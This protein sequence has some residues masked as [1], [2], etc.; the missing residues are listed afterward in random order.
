MVFI[1]P[2]FNNRENRCYTFN[3]NGVEKE[4]WESRS[5]AVNLCLLVKHKGD[6]YVLCSIRG[7]KAAGFQGCFNLPCGYLDWDETGTEAVHKETWEECGLD[8]RDFI[9]ASAVL[10]NDLEDP[11]MVNTDPSENRQ[12]V[13]LRYGAYVYASHL[14]LLTPKHNEVE[15]ETIKPQWLKVS[16]VITKEWAFGHEHIIAR[17]KTKVGNNI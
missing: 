2:S 4:V 16:E 7:P 6:L 1:K 8:L 14:P 9:S 3:D 15:G 10:R 5:V 13:S 11:Y 17:Y 12:N